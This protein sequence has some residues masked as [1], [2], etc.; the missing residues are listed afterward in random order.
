MYIDDIRNPKEDG[1]TIFRNS[2]DALLFVEQKL[3]EIKVISFDHDLGGDDTT[4]PVAIFLEE[5]ASN[6]GEVLN[7]ETIVHSAN[8]VGKLWLQ[9][10]LERSTKL[11]QL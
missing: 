10:A 7:I 8:P 3:E 1:W 11:T 6:K 2:K 9:K 4:R 5:M